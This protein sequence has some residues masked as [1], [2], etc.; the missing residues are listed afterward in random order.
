MNVVYVTTKSLRGDVFHSF[1]LL[2]DV[3]VSLTIQQESM[4]SR[5]LT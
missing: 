3:V 5:L 1:I 4:E 2:Y